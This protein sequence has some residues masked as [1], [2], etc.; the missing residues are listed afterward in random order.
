MIYGAFTNTENNN[1]EWREKMRNQFDKNSVEVYYK[2]VPFNC[3]FVFEGQ[4]YEKT[5]YHRGFYHKDG[6]MVFKN[7]RKTHIIKTS[8]EYFD[9]IPLTK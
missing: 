4:E 3:K 8:R 9:F 7:F 5:N 2:H 1:E 6:R